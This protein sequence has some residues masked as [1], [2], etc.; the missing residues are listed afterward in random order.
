MRH[1]S[2]KD[3]Q[4]PSGRKS[5]V[6][7]TLI[8]NAA[9]RL[10]RDQGY[11]ATTLRQIADAANMK[12]G[13]IYYHFGSK[14]E[15][16]DEVLDR[17]VRFVFDAVKQAVSEA[18]PNASYRTRIDCAI[19]AHLEALLEKNDYT[20]ANFRIY[21]QLPDDVK[22][23]HR[24]LRQDY[25]EYWDTLLRDGQEAGEIRTDIAI[26]QLRMLILGALNWSL[27]WFNPD[28]HSVETLAHQASLLVMDG[29]M[30]RR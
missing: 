20:S 1:I 5:A 17:G 12:A 23:K 7:R 11:V 29:I 14:E 30:K 16:L 27:E 3:E 10:L 4:G 8:L 24:Q 19:T 25:G 28:K 26:A 6:S 15:I 22:A 2:S 18:G 21:G 13:S 9:A